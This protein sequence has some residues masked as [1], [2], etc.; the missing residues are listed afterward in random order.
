MYDP[1]KPYKH[2]IEKLI[3]STWKNPNITVKSDIYTIFRRKHSYLEVDHT[4][5]IGS[6]AEYHWKH[7]TFS[8]AVQD[9]LAMN[10]NDLA[11]V[12]AKGYKLQNHIMLPTDDHPAIIEIVKALVKMCKNRQIVITGGETSIHSIQK[13][14]DV[15]MC[16]SGYIK[17]FKPNRIFD[18]DIL[19]GLPSDGLHSNGFTKVSSTLK[20]DVLK[21]HIKPTRIYADDVLQVCNKVAVHGMMHITG[22]AFTKLK[23]IGRDVDISVSFDN[24]FKQKEV[25]SEIYSRGVS[26]IDMYRIFNCGIGYVLSVSPKDVNAALKTLKGGIVIGEATKGDGE[27]SIR[28]VFSKKQVVY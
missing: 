19:I 23:D 8:W 18:G 24:R 22:G 28:S 9:V 17:K 6:K 26:D 14:F 21:S 16:V 25:F 13:F 4:D 11:M 1:T 5:G 20:D 27:I 3:S 12:R 15:S 10:L 7:R 2:D